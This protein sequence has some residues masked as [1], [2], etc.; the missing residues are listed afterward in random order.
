MD[1]DE[2]GDVIGAAPVIVIGPNTVTLSRAAKRGCNDSRTSRPWLHADRADRHD[3]GTFRG[4]GGPARNDAFVAKDSSEAMVRAQAASIA[5]AYLDEVLSRPVTDPD[6]GV[7]A[8]RA[9]FDNTQDYNGLAN[10]NGARDQF[11]NVVPGLQNYGVT[12]AVAATTIGAGALAL[13]AGTA[14]R[15]DVTV[16]HSSGLTVIATGYRTP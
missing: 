10:P 14:R 6:G 3:R 9:L 11:D 13:P 8:G 7:E 2:R 5:A 12:V 4:R 15:V 1:F 16:R